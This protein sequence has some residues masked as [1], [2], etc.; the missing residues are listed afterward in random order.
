MGSWE[1]SLDYL[2]CLMFSLLGCF[3]CIGFSTA[4]ATS[5]AYVSDCV[6]PTE[7]WVPLVLA[8]TTIKPTVLFRSR[9]FSLWS[10]VIFAGMA[11][12][13]SLGSFITSY[14]QNLMVIFYINVVF[15]L[16]YTLFVAFIL[17]E[18]MSPEALR[19]AVE[20]RRRSRSNSG[21][22][23]WKR[24]SRKLLVLVAPL[25]MFLPRTIQKSAGRKL[26]DWNVTFIGLAFALHAT[27]SV[28]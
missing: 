17:P 9:W 13:P 18:S 3:H 24:F 11:L 2:W 28:R 25:G 19:N 21:S 23:W 6:A 8:S 7:R 26:R 12:G 20:F 4:V 22:P 16:V 14:T 27:N 1:A 5:H 10:G 15:D